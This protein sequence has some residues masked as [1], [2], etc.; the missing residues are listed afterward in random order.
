MDKYGSRP[1]WLTEMGWA[2]HRGAYGVGE[3]QQAH[4]LARTY[5]TAL[6]QPNVEKIFWYDFRDDNASG[7][8]YEQ[9]ARNE[10]DNQLHFG[11]LRR[12]FPLDP[13]SASLRKPASSATVRSLTRSPG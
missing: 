9:P 7:A 1:V 13:G 5:I 11:M 12:S 4:F 3:D 6:A 8:S 2:T 10:A